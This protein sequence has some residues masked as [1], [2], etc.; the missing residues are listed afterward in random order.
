LAATPNGADDS[1]TIS[2]NLADNLSGVDHSWIYVNDSP[3]GSAEGEW[4]LIGDSDQTQYTMVWDYTAW[5]P[6]NYLIGVEASDKAGNALLPIDPEAQIVFTINNSVPNRAPDIPVQLSPTDGSSHTAV[7]QLCWSEVI[8]PDGD[9]VQY[10]VDLMLAGYEQSQWIS[11]TCWQPN[12]QAYGTYSWHV[13]A[14]DNQGN[15]SDYSGDW[16]F[17]VRRATATP[18]HTPTATATFTPTPTH[19]PTAIATA[20]FTPTPTHTPVATAVPTQE[21]TATFTP[22][23][24][25]TPRPDGVDSHEPDDSSAEADRIA[26]G[27]P[28]THSI[29]PP[30]DE[31]WVRFSL[32]DASAVTIATSG[33][34]GDTRM[35]LYDSALN[36]VEENDDSDGLFAAIDRTCG[37]EALPA[38]DYYVKIAEYSGDATIEQYVISYTSNACAAVDYRYIF[39]P[40]IER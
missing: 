12:V 23:P 33:T 10:W 14:R 5:E 34:E 28:Q 18:T 17:T 37:F 40:L 22:T 38:G 31:D 13:Q 21:P 20:T 6:G 7:P 16:S 32:T 11:D 3:N 27:A 4:I 9:P 2:V 39:L 26:P 36:L 8:D 19:T 24:I 25:N 30:G 1:T 29:A 35:W 15:K